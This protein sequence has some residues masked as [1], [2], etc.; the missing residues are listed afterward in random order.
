MDDVDAVLADLARWSA[1]ARVDEAA[2]SRTRERWLRQQAAE[3]ARFT[4]V[5]LDLAEAGTGVA[6]WLAG[7]TV[8][9]GRID[10]VAGNFCVLRQEDATATLVAYDAI[11]VV[12]PDRTH[13]PGEEASRR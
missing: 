5:V 6:V 4:G 10:T 11:A 13:R 7:G 8:I 2:R 1:G 3:D 9:H 12:R